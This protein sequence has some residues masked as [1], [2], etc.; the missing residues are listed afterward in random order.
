MT[1]IGSYDAKTNLPRLLDEVEAG[2]SYTITKHGR[3]VA[4]LVGM[5]R[6]FGGRDGLLAEFAKFSEGKTLGTP[7]HELIEQG[8]KW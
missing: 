8:R 4:R 1:T 6:D 7:A 3:P 5:G 2:A